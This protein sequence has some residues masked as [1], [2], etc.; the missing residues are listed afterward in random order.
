[1]ACTATLNRSVQKTTSWLAFPT[2]QAT[3]TQSATFVKKLLAVAI[4]NVAYLR[5][6]FP[7]H[8]FGDKCLE[9]LNLKILREDTACPGA[10]QVIKWMRGCFDAFDKKYLKTLIIGIYVDPENPDTIIESYTFK[11]DYTNNGGM[12]I[13]RNGDKLASAYSPSETKK[14]TI[15]LLRTIVILTQTLNSLPDDV[16][17]TMKLLYYDDVTPADYEPPG[18]QPVD[19]DYFMFDEEPINIKVGDVH[20]PFHALKLR[21]KTDGKQFEE[22]ETVGADSQNIED[23]AMMTEKSIYEKELYQADQKTIQNHTEA[24]SSTLNTSSKLIKQPMQ[25]E[26]VPVETPARPGTED[27]AISTTGSARS[28][29][30]AQEENGVRCPC[31]CNE[32]D[33]L[34]ILCASCRYWQ[35]AVCFGIIDENEAPQNHI[36]N[37]CANEEDPERQPTDPRLVGLDEIAVQATSLWRRALLT[38]SEL[39]RIV[40]PNFARSLGVEMTV[41][42]GLVNRLERE[43]FLKAPSKGKRLGKIVEKEKIKN[44]G[45]KK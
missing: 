33:G 13:Y 27:R 36:C 39:S 20:T 3:E 15:K 16:M 10:S 5:A 31:G 8:A 19:T 21:I 22:Q 28:N 30:D 32:D 2:E 17:M 34:M 43:K 9:D 29:I 14:A 44:E 18:F 6:I 11:F 35:H 12:D 24:S 41:A 37:F 4:S 38:C 1:M 23:E 26:D 42:Q 25:C 40:L 7:E 45:F